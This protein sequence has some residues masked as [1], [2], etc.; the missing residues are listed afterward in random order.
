M[1]YVQRIDIRRDVFWLF[2]FIQA[3]TM[4]ELNWMKLKLINKSY[5]QVM[6]SI[7]SRWKPNQ[8]YLWLEPNLLSAIL[9]RAEKSEC[10][11]S[12]SMRLQSSFNVNIV[13]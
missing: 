10:V 4:S 1:T 13:I 11:T 7:E 6:P 8:I 2:S 5:A 3:D 12:N 9:K